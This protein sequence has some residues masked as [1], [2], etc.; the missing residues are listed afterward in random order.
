MPQFDKHL[1]LA[2]SGVV[3]GH[4]LAMT[5]HGS[6]ML[7]ILSPHSDSKGGREKLT[8]SA[9]THDNEVHPFST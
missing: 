1:N 3:G 8:N 9:P 5:P 7:A 6:P 4:S 2:N